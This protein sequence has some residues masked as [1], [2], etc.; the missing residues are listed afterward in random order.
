MST[1][2]E[3]DKTVTLISPKA[4]LHHSLFLSPSSLLQVPCSGSTYSSVSPA[5]FTLKLSDLGT[6]WRADVRVDPQGSAQKDLRL[7]RVELLNM[8]TGGD[9]SVF[10]SGGVVS[11]GNIA[12]TDRKV[13]DIND[14]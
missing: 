3:L 7:D 12:Y 11:E 10:P 8:T 14:G 1:N 2:Y 13:R 9:P 4:H 5:V 6:P